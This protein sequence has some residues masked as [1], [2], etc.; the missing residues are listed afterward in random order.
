MKSFILRLACAS[1]IGALA[2]A[3]QAQNPQYKPAAPATTD[4][5][6]RIQ[7]DA[8]YANAKTICEGQQ[9]TAKVTCLKNAKADYE[10]WLRTGEVDSSAMP[11]NAGTGAKGGGLTSGG[12][13]VK[14]KD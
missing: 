4:A 11:G 12:F 2:A 8:A 7:A 10:R 5:D 1:A 14:N 13:P 9:G 3:A 6:V